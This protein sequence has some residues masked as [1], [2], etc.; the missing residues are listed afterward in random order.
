MAH[1]FGNT[2]IV[3]RTKVSVV[4]GIVDVFTSDVDSVNGIV[5]VDTN[6]VVE[7]RV[8]GKVDLVD[9]TEI[10]VEVTGVEVNVIVMSDCQA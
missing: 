2:G 1:A 6:V 4:T 8:S 3:E 10:T 5:L 7:V 9:P